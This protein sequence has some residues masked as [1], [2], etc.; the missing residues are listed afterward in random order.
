V[1][2]PALEAAWQDSFW[3]KWLAVD[4]AGLIVIGGWSSVCAT[5]RD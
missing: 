5:G 2:D 4:A 1:H 3:W